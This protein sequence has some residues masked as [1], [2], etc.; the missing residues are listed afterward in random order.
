MRPTTI[1]FMK[2]EYLQLMKYVFY[3]YVRARKSVGFTIIKYL[4]LGVRL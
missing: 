2:Y 1:H 4:S 3:M